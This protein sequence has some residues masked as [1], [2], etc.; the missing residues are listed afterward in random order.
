MRILAVLF[1]I[2]MI[3]GALYSAPLMLEAESGIINTERAEVIADSRYSG[4]KGVA[5]QIQTPSYVEAT[6]TTTP[7]IVLKITLPSPGLYEIRTW[8]GADKNG[9]AEL[10][11]ATTVRGSKFMRLQIDSGIP[12][13]RVIMVP[14]LPP[15]LH[16]QESGIFEF[17]SSEAELK[18]WLPRHVRLDRLQISPWQPPAVPEKCQSYVPPI[19]MPPHPRLWV[20]S[21]VLPE[22]K[23]A[24]TAPTHAPLWEKVQESA[25]TPYPFNPPSNAELEYS[26]E[27]QTAAINKAFVYL[28]TGDQECGREAIELMTKYLSLVEFG[29]LLDV[30]RNIGRAISAGAM[31]YDWCYPLMT[32]AEKDTMRSNMLRLARTMEIGWPPFKQTIVNGHGNEAQVNC[33]LLSMAIAVYDEDPE[34][35]KY[36]AYLELENLFPMRAIEY[37]S[38][39]HN[40]GLNYASFR[41]NW[42]MHAAW[43]F[44]RLTGE[45]LFPSGV[46]TLL[47]YVH[48][49]R[50]PSGSMLPDGDG[51][52]YPAY[53]KPLDLTFMLYTYSGNPQSKGE[54]I[55]QGGSVKDPVLF[56]LL[57]DPAL[58]ADL[59]MNSLPLTRF[60]P[61][62]LGSMSART[63]WNIDRNS[64]DI[65]VAMKGAGKMFGNHQ[66]S[67]YGSFQIYFRGVLAGDLGQYAFYG[68]P[69][70]HGF[71]KRS[72]AHSMLLVYDPDEK[73]DY[74]PINDGGQRYVQDQPLTVEQMLFE[75]RFDFGKVLTCSWGPDRTVP[76]F[77]YMSSD[78]TPAYSAKVSYH[79]REF[80][81]INLKSS[82][83]AIKGLLLV[84]DRVNT[85]DPANRKIWQVNS[86]KKPEQSSD[87]IRIFSSA[88]GGR[89]GKLFVQ[90]LLPRM[91]ELEFSAVGGDGNNIDVFGQKL[92]SPHPKQ[93][94]AQGYRNQFSPKTAD[95]DTT[96]L[97]ALQIG[98]KDAKELPVST[99]LWES[100]VIVEFPGWMI[101]FNKSQTP[102]SGDLTLHV[103]SSGTK[104]LLTGVQPGNWIAYF[105]GNRAETGVSTS[106]EGTLFF[107]APSAGDVKLSWK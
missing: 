49:M 75:P 41:L 46:E 54:F 26:P 92:V 106:D 32:Q 7:D 21:Q 98:D 52:G 64:D 29:N 40:Q 30:S 19:A 87:G 77:S 68:T 18:I 3:S 11:R 83:D 1:L 15:E 44:Y 99:R 84:F 12:T 65:L 35:F 69:Y 48:Y 70:D 23:S 6:R 88:P 4:G 76:D 24:L 74:S 72:I 47:D 60:F 95:T 67:D 39:R 56:L 82:S 100:G 61:G 45:K 86:F 22:I 71:N 85:P 43:L 104:V 66:H 10:Q 63:G 58:E 94:E 27:L 59:D 25:Q 53:W 17:S 62:V 51:H 38:S 2:L 78:L 9:A 33:D 31:V 5:L 55:R 37:K 102:L 13:K 90:P 34:A 97:F 107:T 96:L 89:V 36:C 105:G 101:F 79:R 20:N 16:M 80:C 91:E 42:E 57:D 50:T 73:F 81:F 103:P 8:A 93:G 28:M 14:W